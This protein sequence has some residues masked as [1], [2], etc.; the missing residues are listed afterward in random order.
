MPAT[1]ILV[2]FRPELRIA[3]GPE[4]KNRQGK[5]GLIDRDQWYRQKCRN[6]LSKALDSRSG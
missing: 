3:A 4:L 5:T 2:L 6:S 1:L